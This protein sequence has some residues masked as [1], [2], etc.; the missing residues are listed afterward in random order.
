[1][2]LLNLAA[3]LK[4]NEP[5]CLGGRHDLEDVIALRDLENED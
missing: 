1:M 5:Y 3:K 4:D 2:F